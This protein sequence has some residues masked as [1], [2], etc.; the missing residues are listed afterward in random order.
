[1][2]SKAPLISLEQAQTLVMYLEQGE[3]AAD[4]EVGDRDAPGGGVA[5]RDPG[6]VD[7]GGDGQFRATDGEQQAEHE[8]DQATDRDHREL[9]PPPS[10]GDDPC[11]DP[12]EQHG[13]TER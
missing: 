2:K 7:H 1:M 9:G 13:P 8:E 4:A 10:G 3:Q 6:R 12:Q 11:R 5:H